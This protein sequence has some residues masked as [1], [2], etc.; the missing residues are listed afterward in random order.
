M[1]NKRNETTSEQ[2]FDQALVG[3]SRAGMPLQG[4][5]LIPVPVTPVTDL[6]SQPIGSSFRDELM[7][8]ILEKRPSLTREKLS[9]QMDE[10]GF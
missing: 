1:S 3:L 2:I 9:R 4:D 10:M 5:E 7:D 6:A 8:E